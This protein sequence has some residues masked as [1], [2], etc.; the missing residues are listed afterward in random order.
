MAA[1]SIGEWVFLQ[2]QASAKA[3]EPH[4]PCLG[5]MMCKWSLHPLKGE[6]IQVNT[7]H[8]Q[9]LDGGEIRSF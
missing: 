8:V 4:V 1:W 9:R 5:H 6:A 3:C 7:V 2:R